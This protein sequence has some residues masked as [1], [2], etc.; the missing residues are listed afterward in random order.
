VCVCQVAVSVHA[1]MKQPSSFS[2]EVIED[3]IVSEYKIRLAA[4][5]PRNEPLKKCLAELHLQP[6]DVLLV[7][8]ESIECCFLCSS[9]EQLMQLRR[10]FESGVM[11]N[12][13]QN[14]FTLLMNGDELIVINQLKWDPKNYWEGVQKLNQLKPL[15]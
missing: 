14:I 9:T 1:E 5:D 2:I 3:K 11:K 13:L 10:L 15:G 6:R 4:D 12:V 7:H 8:S